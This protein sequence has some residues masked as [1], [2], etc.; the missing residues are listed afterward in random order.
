MAKTY[1]QERLSP[2]LLT[3]LQAHSIG[4]RERDFA[5]SLFAPSFR[6]FSWK[7][8]IHLNRT[9]AAVQDL[10]MVGVSSWSIIF[11][12]VKSFQQMV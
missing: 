10:A 11:K 1:L 9:L 8:K 4:A 5:V 2:S 7:V 12:W 6:F 3:A